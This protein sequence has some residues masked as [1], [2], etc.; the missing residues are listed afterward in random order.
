[1]FL[2]IAE[3][4][5]GGPREA[6]G[7]GRPRRGAGGT[8]RARWFR[9]GALLLVAMVSVLSNWVLAPAP[10]TALTS[11]L[12]YTI[13]FGTGNGPQEPNGLW[14]DGETLW[15]PN[16]IN[17]E[18]RFSSANAIYTVRLPSGEIGRRVGGSN[19]LL[20]DAGN[21]APEGIW[22][23]GTTMWVADRTDDK[24]YAY[25]FDG[26]RK[27]ALDMDLHAD[28]KDPRGIWGNEDTIWVANDTGGG[29]RKIFAY[30]R[31]DGTRDAAKDFNNMAGGV[32]HPEGIWSDGTTM[33]V[34]DSWSNKVFAYRMSDK[35]RD[36]AR[37][38]DL[39]NGSPSGL[40]SPDGITFYVI[41]DR[42]AALYVYGVPASLLAAELTVGQNTGAGTFGYGA[43]N[44]GGAL[45]PATFALDG[46]RTV[47]SLSYD[48]DDDELTV[49]V[50]PRLPDA[51]VPTPLLLHVD[52]TEFG[53]DDANTTTQGE[54]YTEFTWQNAGL[55]WANG[56]AVHIDVFRA[57]RVATG[58][59]GVDGPPVYGGT[60]TPDA[61]SIVDPDG[62]DE[63]TFHYRWLRDGAALA[64]GSTFTVQDFGNR[65]A[66]GHRIAVRITYTDDAGF[67]E[68]FTTP[69]TYIEH[70]FGTFATL[71]S[72]R[73]G[74]LGVTWLDDDD[75]GARRHAQE[76]TTGSNPGGYVLEHIGVGFFQVDDVTT[77][78]TSL[79]ATL[80][81]ASDSDPGTTLCTLQH[82]SLYK[83]NRLLDYTAAGSGCPTLTPDTRYFIVVERTEFGATTFDDRIGLEEVTHDNEAGAPGWSVANAARSYEHAVWVAR[84]TTS[85]LAI[86]V[87]ASAV[88]PPRTQV[89]S[90]ALTVGT[91]VDDADVVG[92]DRVDSLFTGDAL[93]P[94][95]FR[96]GGGAYG[97]VG[98]TNRKHTG[99]EQLT[100]TLSPAIDPLD[101]WRWVPTVEGTALARLGDDDWT[102][103][104]D[105]AADV[106]S[107]VLDSPGIS[108][109]AGETVALTVTRDDV[110]V[111][112]TPREL[113]VAEGGSGTYTVV[114]NSEP[115][116]NVVVTVTAAEGATVD[117]DE[118]TFTPSTWDAP[119][120]VTVSG[121]TDDDANDDEVTVSHAVKAGS[122]TEYAGATI[123]GVAV[124]VDDDDDPGVTVT[125]TMV[126][127]T[128]EGAT[129]TYTVVLDVPPDG[130]VVVEVT[131]T[132]TEPVT[133]RV[134]ETETV[135]A[136]KSELTFTAADWNTAQTVTVS[137]AADDDTLDEEATIRHAVK[138]GSAT[139]YVG[140]SIAGV[141]VTVTDDDEPGVTVTPTALT[142][143]EDSSGEYTVVLDAEPSEA[144]VVSATVAGS[145]ASLVPDSLT[146]QTHNWNTARTMTV[147]GEV[148][149]DADDE[150]ATIS[151]AVTP[152]EGD[153]AEYDG[154]TIDSV[155]VTVIDD[156]SPGLAFGDTSVTVFEYLPASSGSYAVWLALEPSGTVTVSISGDDGTDLSLLTTSLMFTTDNWNSA[157]FVSYTA[158]QDDD[159]A[160]DVLT[161]SHVAS[162]G[163]Y[164]GVT[165]DL[166]VTI[167]DDDAG[168]VIEPSELDVGEDDSATYTVVLAASRSAR[169]L[170]TVTVT[171]SGHTG[172]DLTLSGATLTGS[173]LT[174]TTSN[175][176]MPQTVTVTAVGDDDLTDDTV[177][178]THTAAGSTFDGFTEPLT[179][180][181]VDDDAGFLIEPAPLTVGEG[182]TETYTLKL[183][184]QPSGQ[185]TVSVSGHAGT[186]V[187]LSTDMLTFSMSTWN[188]AQTVTV[189]AGS[190]IDAANDVVTLDH[191]ATGGDYGTASGELT[192]T[193][194]DDDAALVVAPSPSLPVG[195]GD[196]ATYTVKLYARPAGSVTVRIG[197]HVGNDV[198]LS[199]ARLTFS[200]ANWATA[201]TV[202]V[203]AEHDDDFVNDTVALSHSAGG[204]DYDDVVAELSVT[205]SDDDEAGLVIEPSSLSVD[206]E[207]AS[208]TY[209]VW[210]A[211]QPSGRVTVAVSGHSGGEV[212]LG[213]APLTFST[214]NWARAQTVAVTAPG[215]ADAAH[216][217]V[218]LNHRASGGGYDVSATLPVT[219]VDDDA[220]LVIAP[221]PLPVGE[222]DTATYTVKLGAR[223]AG[224]VTV[225]IGGHAGS[226][227]SLSGSS[228]SDS[229]LT[230]STSTWST[231]QT[232]TVTA[233]E[234]DDAAPD[235]VTLTHSAT[236][237]DYDDESKNLTV[238]VTDNDAELVIVSSPV[239][240]TEEGT[241]A[242]YTVRLRAP[243]GG[244]VT[245]TIS[246]HE[247]NDV[248]L[249][250]TQ[251]R[252]ST[253]TWNTAQTV[254][255]T[256]EAD[257]D[258]A[259]NTVTLAHS[260]AGGGYDDVAEDVTVNITDNDAEL[261]I[262]P[263][264][265]GLNEGTS[266]S[267]LVRLGALP[268]GLVTVTI[269]GHVGNGLSLSTEKLTF[270]TATWN[271]TQPVTVTAAEDDDAADEDVTLNHRASGG[272][273]GHVSVDLPVDIFDID[274]PGLVFDPSN[275]SLR[276]AEDDSTTY[277]VEL[278]TQPTADVTV[279]ISGHA[280]TDVSLDGS[281]L[282]DSKLTF[283]ASNWSTAQTVTVTAAGDD[284][285]DDDTVTLSHSASGGDY[286]NVSADVT[287]TVTDDSDAGLVIAPLSFT[288]AEEGAAKTYTVKLATQP[289][290]NVTVTVGGHATST[291]SLSGS[292][293]SGSKLTFTPSN[294][295]AAQTVTVTAAGDDDLAGETVQLSHSADGGGY[296]GVT[297]IL[298][299]SVT[300]T[301]VA[302]LVI[303]PSSLTVI[304]EGAAGTYTVRLNALPSGEVTVLLGGYGSSDV[305]L[306]GSSLTSSLLTFTTDD[307]STAQTVTVTARSDT[308][309]VKDTVTLTHSASGGG[310]NGVSKDVEVTVTDD[311]DPGLVINPLS[312]TVAEQGSG[313]SYTVKLVAA[314]SGNVTVTISGHA[315]SDVSLSG[316]SLSDSKLTFTT[317]NWS[318][319]QRVIVTAGADD[320]LADETVTLTHSATGGGYN[321]SEV[322]TVTVTDN[323]VAALVIDPSSLTVIEEGAAKTYTVKLNALPSANVTVTVSG[324]ATTDVSLSATSFSGSKL[325][326][327]T[328]NWSAA[329]T[330]TVTAAADADLADETVTLAHSA[331]GG[332]FAGVS[333]D[334]S[335]TVDDDDEAGLVTVPSELDLDEEGVAKTYTVRLAAQPSETVTVSVSGHAGTTVSLN[336]TTFS[337][338]KLTFTRATWETEQTVTVTAAGDVDLA[339]EIVRLTHSASGG[340]YD[341]ESKVVTVNVNDDDGAGLVIAPP[342]VDVTE[343]GATATY[344]VKLEAQP[345]E[346]VTVTVGGHAGTT[347]SLSATS[348]HGSELTFT[349]ADWNTAQTVTVTAAADD[350]LADETVPLTHSADSGGYDGVTKVVTVTVTDNDVAGLV[351]DPLSLGVDE[352][353]TGTYRVKLSA[354]P[355]AEVT[356][357]ISGH[358]NTD[359]GLSGT[360]LTFTTATWSATQAVTVTAERDDDLTDDTETLTHTADGG[361]FAGVT[362][363]V[364][365]TIDDDDVAALVIAPSPFSVG[366][367]AT[368]TY[369]VKL[370]AQPSA[371]VTVTIGGHATSDVSLSG[372]SLSGSKLTFTRADW[373][374]EQTVTVSATSDIDIED[375]PVTLTHTAAGGGYDGVTEDLAVT[376][377]DDDVANLVVEPSSVS[378]P[379]GGEE[380]FTVK[381]AKLPSGNVTVTISDHGLAEVIVRPKSLTFTT[382]DW[383][384]E[385]TV[386]VSAHTD[387]NILNDVEMLTYSASGGGYGDAM[388]DLTVTVVDD[389]AKLVFIPDPSFS[390][391]EGARQDYAVGLAGE[392]TGNVTVTIS[393]HENAGTLSSS[394]LTGSSLTFTPA[395][396]ETYQGVTFTAAEDD[397]LA[398]GT[399]TLTHS[400][401]GGGY[402]TSADVT[403]TVTDN[404][405]AG[406]VIAPSPLS[407]G[408]GATATYTVKLDAQPSE[409]VTVTISG[410]ENTDVSLSERKL[411]FA[412]S[413]WDTAQTVTVTAGSDGDIVEDTVT[414]THSAVGGDYNVSEVLTVT[415]TELAGAALVIDPLLLSVPEGLTGTYTVKLAVEPSADVTVTISGHAGTDVGLS[416]TKLTFTP[417]TWSTVQTVT[418]TATADDDT[419][420]DIVTLTHSAAGGGYGGV[421]KDLRVTVTDDA[422]LVI[423]PRPLRVPEGTTGMYT[424]KLAAPPSAN[425]KVTISG[426]ANT[427]V[428][429]STT[430]LTFTTTDWQTEQTVRVTTEAD[431][432][433]ANVNV[434]LT[435]DAEG[436]GYNTVSAELTVVV[437]DNAAFAQNSG[438]TKNIVVPSGIQS[439]H[440]SAMTS[441]G[442][443]AWLSASGRSSLYASSLGNG[444]R[445]YAK[446]VTLPATHVGPPALW[447]D[448]DIIWVARGGAIIAYD[449]DADTHL[450]GFDLTAPGRAGHT[451]PE[452]IWSDGETMWIAND[453]GTKG[454]YAYDPRTDTHLPA[455]G[456]PA[457]DGH[458]YLGAVWSDGVTIWVAHPDFSEDSALYAYDLDTK[459]RRSDLDFALASGNIDPEGIWSDGRTMWVFD[460][461]SAQTLFSFT[462]ATIFA[463]NMPPLPVL[464]GLQLSGVDFGPFIVGRYG[465]T[466]RVPT[467]VTQ[468][469]V[470]ATEAAAGAVVSIS[471]G[472]ADTITPGHQV[473][474][475]AGENTITIT[476]SY[477][478]DVRTY[479]VVVDRSND[480]D[481]VPATTLSALTLSGVDFGTFAPATEK[482]ST[483]VL[484]DVMRTTVTATRTEDTARLSISPGDADNGT[485]GHQV[486]LQAGEDTAITVTLRNGRQGPRTYT[487]TVTRPAQRE[488]AH[489][490]TLST[491]TLSGIDFTFD[492]ATTDYTLEAPN[493]V[494][495]TTITATPTGRDAT[496]T[497]SRG[498]A[499]SST[500]GHQIRLD[501]GTNRPFTIVVTSADENATKTY[502]INVTRTAAETYSWD[503][504]PTSRPLGHR[505]RNVRGLWSDGTTLWAADSGGA[506]YAYT[507]ANMARDHEK[508]FRLGR[509]NISGL[510]SDGTTLWVSSDPGDRIFAY[511]LAT[512]ARDMD[513][514]IV[515]SGENNRNSRGIWSDGTTIWTVDHKRNSIYAY[516]LSTGARVPN[517]GRVQI[518]GL[519]LTEGSG[520]WSNG[521][522]LWIAA[523]DRHDVI[524]ITLRH[525]SIRHSFTI[526]DVGA[527]GNGSPRGVWSDGSTVWVSDPS[528]DRIYAY[529]I[530]VLAGVTVTPTTLTI[531]EGGS[532]TYTVVP[533]TELLFG[534]GVA[535]AAGDGV[536]VDKAL[537]R[538]ENTGYHLMPDW[539][540]PQTVTVTAGTDDD[541]D[542]ETVTITH[543]TATG[544]STTDALYRN[545]AMDSVTVTV[546]DDDGVTV[547]RRRLTVGEGAS[548]SYT[549]VL[550]AAPLGEV[551][552]GVTAG[553]GV[554]VAPMSLTFTAA[555]WNTAQ[556]VSVTGVEDDD[557]TDE[558][559][560]ITHRV[561]SDGD[562]RFMD[563]DVG[564]VAVTVTDDDTGVAVAPT[565]LTVA[566]GGTGSYTM[567]LSTAPT[568]EVV[569][570]VTA[571]E[572][573]TV[574]PMS[575]TFTAATWNTAQTVMVTAVTDDN[576]TGEE[577][578]ITHRVTSDLDGGFMGTDVEAVTVTVLDVDGVTVSRTALT[579]A[580]GGTGSYTVV[581][582]VAPTDDVVVSVTAGAGVT[583]APMSL[584]FTTSNWET[585]QTVRVTGAA[586]DD[587]ADE[588]VTI[589]HAV[590]DGSAPEYV[591]LTVD[592]VT[593][594]V[595]DDDGPGV[596]LDPPTSTELK[597]R[598]GGTSTY[599]LVLDWRPEGNVVIDITAGPSP[600][601]LTISPGSLTFTTGTW[602]AAQTVTVQAG[603]DADEVDEAE[604]TITHTIRAAA[605]SDEYDEV[606]V[607]DVLVNCR[608]Q[609]R[610]RADGRSGGPDDQG[611]RHRRVHR[612][613]RQAAH[614]VG[615]HQHVAPPRGDGR[616]DLARVHDVGL[617]RGPDGDGDGRVDCRRHQRPSLGRRGQ[618]RHRVPRPARLR[619]GDGHHRRGS[620]GDGE[621]DDVERR[622]GHVG[623]LHGGVGRGAVGERGGERG[624]GRG[625]HGRQER[626]DVHA[627]DVGDGA[628]GD[629][630][631][632]PGW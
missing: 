483:S 76:F 109:Q 562:G 418:V 231:A 110:F 23:D 206:E 108:W 138:A 117:K 479:T 549:V 60:L 595:T 419:A 168:L 548:G 158:A 616:P 438:R 311:D 597:M 236:G 607:P 189:T 357:T 199:R 490:D 130:N 328:S 213:G 91:S 233:A 151:H 487:V 85:S 298:T 313:G 174:F 10:A 509:V 489:V 136:D 325:T 80:R 494:A 243:P 589:S 556:T 340:D 26:S 371:D 71:V 221:S 260:A 392:P 455:R 552:V 533:D 205:V 45:S 600:H 1:M 46:T 8:R 495:V 584:T 430:K 280:T 628:E 237:G 164:D 254:T 14:G 530:P 185:V 220:E 470:T 282:N 451:D 34:A 36:T 443:T 531:D 135:T 622:R 240:V 518:D 20:Y 116:A 398:D 148:D 4:R 437:V 146:F 169:P 155:E 41:D 626:I 172:S 512:G 270:S 382:G 511:T 294:W 259:H 149:G 48:Q 393:G 200:T 122:D 329:Q 59:P 19:D 332:D 271:T 493:D 491:L 570:G 119:Q 429:L 567:E 427:D 79:V 314:P 118:L 571:G 15:I 347:V 433:N 209:T 475:G 580:E 488:D 387:R 366:E 25:G 342:G 592:A 631:R 407:V 337:G 103:T 516:N 561:T 272:H 445:Q 623:V 139:E 482:Y 275:L 394:R 78:S 375:D 290:G 92:H 64:S 492:P 201:Q 469:T 551:V 12:L 456:I 542:N 289:S 517:R 527:D 569:V 395:T 171:I 68:V 519:G 532:A 267:Y 159:A 111:T 84:E 273:Y 13:R 352:G 399:V 514:E 268:A 341:G 420:N 40:W 187:S 389:S 52:G 550:D 81:A 198:S 293:L 465:Y 444:D 266:D 223:P 615:H 53:F 457:A 222:G 257:A 508:D 77:A 555:T 546:V 66:R 396:W 383:S 62:P 586:D 133:G 331:T 3:L 6:P 170:A 368:G 377:L 403:F 288:V 87:S 286:G 263:T 217:D 191:S 179:V 89:W 524:A 9:F 269:S 312:F 442:A 346:A 553:A 251:L 252:F 229:K 306:S 415:V 343:E 421:T 361:D 274:S 412:A 69:G 18:L 291:V 408:E 95:W 632:R 506:I 102:K 330:V 256:A 190:D 224:S 181:V 131:E 355:S 249:S 386:T 547:S 17:F 147:Y 319:E 359:V 296:N 474:L 461:N 362:K 281:S 481:P 193:V 234:D 529:E 160:D 447:T 374:T 154:V 186:D 515:T 192:V 114:L 502:T 384:T 468:T 471:P 140:V 575:L 373:N 354:E 582:D 425:V 318:L 353:D 246:G 105:T 226:D 522:V 42:G 244:L 253:A 590:E 322:V 554:T 235:T 414:L 380:T 195:E 323:D 484:Y 402:D 453:R 339:D 541:I 70:D 145:G 82:P 604:V 505:N 458:D 485:P 473:I 255:V 67:T 606:A 609:R 50:T 210:L 559:V 88:A 86:S 2:R 44:S 428:S 305:T 376:V 29:I 391:S 462:R 326:F 175:W 507:L 476:V 227:V 277:T 410:H 496:R 348:F 560:T 115:T 113:T 143:D 106:T 157:Q 57:N 585:V 55:S 564:T 537:L 211:A 472:D 613:A 587:D 334:V 534:L 426:H 563:K 510:W 43:S 127:V 338:S 432:D 558:P 499:D 454:I 336:A 317:D 303:D 156:D 21:R 498:D 369:T 441:N 141:A 197:G 413:T 73:S 184:T 422:D 630:D 75:L 31:S 11:E 370:A 579:V 212:L 124:T 416:G 176:E 180:T 477:V 230:F 207:G 583:V 107:F 28:N 152:R 203:T 278:A 624:R 58:D 538:Y 390:L 177:T 621:A 360:K 99:N 611:G 104:R 417:A 188:T 126:A 397:D 182:T 572:G 315:T 545:L 216:E 61:S 33:Y 39:Q 440:W 163:G 228:L 577:V 423:S 47:E 166:P 161:L 261:V 608:R 405:D 308:D 22:S 265:L 302:A 128:E 573:V 356:V 264:S 123:A 344:T 51:L 404:D 142:V 121:D 38:F 401:S 521:T 287:V 523:H 601:D 276:V 536:T 610:R 225:T 501:V 316:T 202:T 539:E 434:T 566:E 480:P 513:K 439:G 599:A 335:V 500:G 112:V 245:V 594:T 300:D 297:K 241:P 204:G 120:T 295:S 35:S 350:D 464:R 309:L 525:L 279:T 24:L 54:N 520:M 134:T 629:G 125:P 94:A 378:V 30:N 247:G 612:E 65:T 503:T 101:A 358:A 452:G 406:L 568:G 591:V 619:D 72:N 450:P 424:V 620:G 93:D 292:S 183:A 363:A 37:E 100:L 283:T 208:E 381:L 49:R 379:E 327:T 218:T 16:D 284:D 258:A 372:T 574:A 321:V 598:E 310:F 435:H 250:T 144:V 173:S 614:R 617:E 167:V 446:D 388:A 262:V 625:R 364:T 497:I 460:G 593:V 150:A 299:V 320:D 239:S 345:S 365:V 90:G 196:T 178:L 242:T 324:H 74:F 411:T 98:L 367:D 32:P 83:A 248:S 162:D 431:D 63:P 486:N 385:Q 194:D 565:A 463:Y 56:D 543:S 349:T 467:T 544:I 557:V 165:A 400:A 576:V 215:D 307:W 436:G 27:A 7:G 627:V 333:G 129:A 232:V 526:N 301:D 448:N 504:L 588:E 238:N 137:G 602:S 351:I 540:T 219:V 153:A 603:E 449:L 214:S 528:D 618:R 581:L 459:A 605:T 132:V 478:A 409:T 97:V 466:A 535:V 285:L 578:M 596:T 304:E 5:P 96:F